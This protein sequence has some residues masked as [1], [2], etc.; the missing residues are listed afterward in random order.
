MSDPGR[1][2]YADLMAHQHYLTLGGAGK[3][4]CRCRSCVAARPAPPPAPAVPKG[5]R[6]IPQAVKVAVAARDSGQCQC[7]A[8]FA[9]HRY[10]GVC[11]ST[12]EPHY[13]HIIPWSKGGT[14]TAD[15]LQILCGPCN[16][17]KG[18]DNIT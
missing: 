11:G 5:R 13:D 8:G 6:A 18:A 2:T 15:N 9:C 7:R 3:A 4:S 12:D 16:R 10:S 17:R 14:D 1:Q